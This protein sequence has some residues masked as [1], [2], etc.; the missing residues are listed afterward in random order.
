MFLLLFISCSQANQADDNSECVSI[1]R[2]D[3]SMQT[4][5]D[6][7]KYWTDE[8]MRNAKPM[9]FPEA[10]VSEDGQAIVPKESLPADALP[11]NAP[12]SAPDSGQQSDPTN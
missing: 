4:D 11:G 12:G 8:R 6:V 1:D 9:P 5:E 3:T 10:V 7:R 2:Q